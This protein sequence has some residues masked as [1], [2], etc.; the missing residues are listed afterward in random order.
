M[1]GKRRLLQREV[2]YEDVKD[3]EFNILHQLDFYGQQLQF[4]TRLWD[5]RDWMKT[6]VAHHLN[7]AT[8][9]MCEVSKVEDW[10]YGS[11]NVCV[12]ININRDQT[13]RVLLRFP[14]PY[15]VGEALNPGNGD[16]KIRCEAA[17]YAWLQENCP[18]IPIT[19]LYGFSLSSGEVY[20]NT[21]SIDGLTGINTGYLLVDFVDKA[22]GQMLSTTWSNGRHDPMLQTN[23]FRDLSRIFLSLF[24]SPLPRIGSL[25]I[26]NQGFLHVANR[27]LSVQIQQLE[28]EGISTDI[29]RD[30]TYSTVDSYLT[31][32]LGVHDNRFRFQ[33][34]AVNHLGDCAYQLSILTAMRTVF[35]SIFSRT[36]RRGPFILSF[37][38][39]HQSNILVD[40]K[41]QI[42]CIVDLEWACSRP[43]E[44]VIP[45]YW[46]TD[47]GVDE[48]IPEEYNSVRQKFMEALVSEE[49]NPVFNTTIKHE[50]D[51]SPLRLSEIM[52]KTW[53][54]GAFW[55]T[56][57]ISS[58]SGL[59]NIF[60]HHIKPLFC[61]KEYDEDFGVV[62]PFFFEKN[63]GVIAARKLADKGKYDEDLKRAFY[64]HT[65]KE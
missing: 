38:D 28:N 13:S 39:L 46:L 20:R 65:E 53:E 27:P 29:S 58:P 17:T 15:R 32:L 60:N 45:P 8:P 30:Y 4:F 43:I 42:K 5:K 6:V 54:S 55:Y 57:G 23:L 50:H 61:A 33:P 34:N 56:I 16:E 22:K 31:D 21:I 59:F 1:S 10:L 47:K 2:T 62:M 9:S 7:L 37:T 36:F 35:Q 52:N 48:I 24:R 14:L 44:M 51:S 41:W 40:D 26:D 63:V 49:R 3:E 64:C 12:P 11:F 18:E 19:Q 25:M